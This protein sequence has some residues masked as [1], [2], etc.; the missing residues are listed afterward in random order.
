MPEKLTEEELDNM[1]RTA[2]EKVFKLLDALTAWLE[3]KTL[4]EKADQFKRPLGE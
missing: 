4:K 3:A 2:S 1:A